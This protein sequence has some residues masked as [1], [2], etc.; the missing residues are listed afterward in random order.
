M[1]GEATCWNT[2]CPGASCCHSMDWDEEIKC[3][4]LKSV[5][6]PFSRIRD[7]EIEIRP[8]LI[9]LSSCLHHKD[10]R[11]KGESEG[12]IVENVFVGRVIRTLPSSSSS[13]LHSVLLHIRVHRCLV[14]HHDD[15]DNIAFR[16]I[17]RLR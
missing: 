5:L 7:R 2:T 10:S 17:D 11:L 16:S 8:V 9:L 14:I 13:R 1:D 4:L 3:S 15:D 6:L 12:S